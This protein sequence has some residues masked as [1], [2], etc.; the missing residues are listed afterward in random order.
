MRKLLWVAGIMLAIIVIIFLLAGTP[1]ILNYVKQKAETAASSATGLSLV[2]GRLRG[3]L[4]YAVQVEDIDLAN[5]VQIDQLAVSYD[6]LRLLAREVD[7]RAV[8]MSGLRVDLDR[9]KE[10]TGNLPRREP[11]ETAGPPTFAL[12][13]R[14]FLIE[15]SGFLGKLGSTPI[16]VSLAAR[17]G[18]LSDVLIID[19]LRLATDESS[20]RITGYVPLN[21]RNDLALEVEMAVAAED[22]GIAGLGGEIRGQGSVGGKFSAVELDLTAHLAINYRE[23]D[24]GGDVRAKWIVPDLNRLQVDANLRAKTKALRRQGN[25]RDST[26][27][28]IQLDNTDLNCNIRSNLGDLL[29]RG[30]LGGDLAKPSFRGTLEGDFDYADFEPSFK[31][32][33][34]YRDDLLEVS[35]FTF[36]SSRVALD[37]SLLMNTATREISKGRVDLSCNDLSVWNT[38]FTAPGNLAGQL[39]L[40]LNMS[41]SLDD[42]K[43]KAK[44]RITDAEVYTEKI[45]EVDLELSMSGS[46][47]YLDSGWIHSE[48][49]KVMLSGS[50]ELKKKDFTALLYSDGIAFTS[51]EVFGKAT[52]PLGGIVGLDLSAH[53]NVHAPRVQGEISIDD[54]LYDSLEF[55]DYRIECQLDDDTLQFSFVSE[56][57]DLVLD[58]TMILGSGFPCTADLELRHYALDRY[59]SPATGYITA[60]VSGTGDLAQIRDAEGKVQIDTV[61]LLVDGRPIENSDII[62]VHLEDRIFRL[63]SAE[64]IIA[65]QSLS[66]SGTMPMQLHSDAMDIAARAAE[67]QLGDIA[68]LLPRNPDIRGLLGFELRIQGT[69]RALDVDGMLSLTGASYSVNNIAV[70][71]VNGLLTLR[72]GLA[73]VDNLAGK[74]NKGRFKID[75]FADFSRGL[76]DTMWVNL[77]ADKINYANKDFGDIVLSTNLQARARKDSLWIT[78]EV[79]INEATY[80]APMKLQTYVKLLTDA[81]RPAPQ[82][83]EISRRVYCDIGI[84]VPD[85]IMIK[86]NIADLAVRADLQL[87]GYLAR[88]NV[89]GTI[90]AMEDGTVKYLGKK[91][92]IANAIIQFDDPYKIDPFIDLMA[93]TT[94]DAAEGDYEIFLVLEGTVTTWQ[95]EL[96]SSPPLPEQDI[97]SLLLIGQRRPGAAGG[98]VKEFD[99]KGKVWDYALDVV[100]HSLE[101]TTE[102]AL[103]LDKFEIS[104]DL[105]DRATMRIGLEKSVTKGFKLHYSTGVESWELYQVGASYDLTDKISIFTM[106]DQENRNTSVD[107]E[108]KLKIK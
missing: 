64:F 30:N 83:A 63:L 87:K 75:G 34:N 51:P 3:N 93:T 108:F 76:L 33:V 55:G 53:G 40:E 2:I 81:N 18:M 13:I 96:N 29:M 50:Y 10:I 74:I 86:N 11:G 20:V 14:E 37:V 42:P 22:F 107:L 103:R 61:R 100:R 71:S 101:R 98:F 82:Q 1:F 5:I 46:V 8:R 65:G 12:R 72:N 57:E 91:F 48:R 21:E 77:K 95:L 59:I 44:L 62:H 47:A 99:L 58:A 27:L 36:R 90:T 26:D 16:E 67:I 19:S 68:Y 39:S 38:F 54:L 28:F 56:E 41:G 49:G 70:D 85:S 32:Q 52:V 105:N 17:G 23:N 80:N 69:T 43:A 60:Q 24:L 79:A 9:L 89:F 31:G 45:D 66:I 94:I 104:G 92:T 15:N 25:L 106:Y 6:P 84:V 97:V 78:G 88:L 4:F 35:G 73:T 7:I 102:N